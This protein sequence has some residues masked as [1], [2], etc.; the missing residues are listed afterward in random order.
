MLLRKRKRELL[1]NIEDAVHRQMNSGSEEPINNEEHKIPQQQAKRKNKA[2]V[3][4]IDQSSIK[5][6]FPRSFIYYAPSAIKTLHSLPASRMFCNLLHYNLVDIFNSIKDSKNGAKTLFFHI[7][8]NS[9]V[10][11]YYYVTYPE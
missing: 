10:L 6:K 2:D 7:F 4:Q 8:P 11:L 3:Y 5:R 1:K 9:Y